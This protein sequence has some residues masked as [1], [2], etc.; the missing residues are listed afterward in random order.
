MQDA[1][2]LERIRRKFQSLRAVLD[3][4]SRRQWAAAEAQ[5]LGYGGVSAVAAATGLARDTIRAGLRELSYRQAHPHDWPGSR[6][7][8]SGGGRKPLTA[9][10]PTLTAAFRRTDHAW[11]PP[12]Q[13]A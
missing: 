8:Q 3:E 9:T 5:E 1:H 12:R 4:R 11:S 13:G 7:R 6:L 2:Q 10:D